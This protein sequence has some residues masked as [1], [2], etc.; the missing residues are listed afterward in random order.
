MAAHAES[1]A[2]RQS[3]AWSNLPGVGQWAL[4]PNDAPD[5]MDSGVHMNL[6]SRSGGQVSS[7]GAGPQR[8]GRPDVPWAS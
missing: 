7:G 4:R 2:G 5:G 8:Q 1:D 6:S 3:S